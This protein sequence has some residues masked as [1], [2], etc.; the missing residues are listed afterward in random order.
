[1]VRAADVIIELSVVS[2]NLST[3][4]PVDVSPSPSEGV[5]LVGLG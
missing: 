4:R 3:H 5:I 2:Q 1:M